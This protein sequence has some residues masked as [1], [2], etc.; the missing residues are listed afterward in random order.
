MTV[1]LESE[2]P[3]LTLIYQHLLKTKRSPT[4][5]RVDY[6]S[7]RITWQRRPEAGWPVI[8]CSR[9]TDNKELFV[10]ISKPGPRPLD[11]ALCI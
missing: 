6:Q 4:Y 9:P 7:K 8:A 10:G 11:S 1:Y 2:E 5:L 3:G